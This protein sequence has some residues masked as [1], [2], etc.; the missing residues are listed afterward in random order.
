V[1][2]GSAT[3]LRQYL[4]DR[5]PVSGFAGAKKPLRTAEHAVQAY[6]SLRFDHRADGALLARAYLL[7]Q[8]YATLRFK[9][10]GAWKVKRP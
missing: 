8:A 4:Q 3:H 2:G 1:S 10:L 5:E 9:A 7:L 6:A